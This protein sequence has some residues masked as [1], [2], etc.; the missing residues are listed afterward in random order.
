MMDQEAFKTLFGKRF[1]QALIEKDLKQSD[2]TGPLNVSDKQIS[3]YATGKGLP[4][5][6][7]LM[8]IC[9]ELNISAD[10]LL[11]LIGEPRP[12]EGEDPIAEDILMM[13]QSY[14]QM[15]D[16]MKAAFQSLVNAI[17]K[18]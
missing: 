5:V 12:L 11:G 3:V 7:G 9:K 13:R 2:L 15:S 16:E 17:L 1:R 6:Y 8:I 14:V 18:Q 10:F 4:S